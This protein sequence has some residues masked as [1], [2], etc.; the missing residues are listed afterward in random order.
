MGRPVSL[1]L[2]LAMSMTSWKLIIGN[3]PLNTFGLSLAASYV[4]PAIQLLSSAMVKSV[5]DQSLVWSSPS[6][7]SD[8]STDLGS[9]GSVRSVRYSAGS[10]VGDWGHFT[11]TRTPG[12]VR[13]RTTTAALVFATS[14]TLV[15]SLS[16]G[17]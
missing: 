16:Q 4:V 11:L 6:T 3:L 14:A 8:F 10:L 5:I 13:L 2:A 7:I 15:L 9:A 12:T 17:L 1:L